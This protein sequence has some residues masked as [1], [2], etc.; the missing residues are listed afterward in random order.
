MSVVCAE[1]GHPNPDGTKFCGECGTRLPA[2]PVAPREVRKVV[3]VLF[4]D[5]TGSTALGERLDPEALR[6]LMTR[7]FATM[8]RIIEAH[9]GTVEKFIGDAVMAVFGIPQVHE[10]DALRAVRAAD[11]IRTALAELNA[12]LEAG[13]GFAIRFRTGLMTGEV[14]AADGASATT[15]VTGDTVNTAARLEQA[16]PPGEILLGEPTYRLVRDAVEVEPV[17]AFEAKGKALPVAAY[18]LLAVHAGAAG[19][20]RRLDTPLVGRERELERLAQAYQDA[21]AHERC[22]LFTLLGTAGVGKSR[23]VADFT[24]AIGDEATVL[25]GRCLSYGDGITYWPISEIVRTASGIVEGDGPDAARAKLAALVAGVRDGG[26]VADRVAA[27]VGL[28]DEPSSAEDVFWAIRR[29]LEHLARERRLVVVIEDIH[30]AEP[31]LLDLIEHIADWSRDAPILLLCPARPELLDAR[32]SWGGGKLNATTVL[33]EPLGSDATSRLIGLLPG[34]SALPAEVADR[35]TRAAEGNPLY[36]EE[37]LG[38][39]VDDGLLVATPGGGWTA[40]AALAELRVPPS[41]GALLAARLE[42]LGSVERLVAEHASVVGRVFEQDAVAALTPAAVRPEVRSALMALVRKELVRPDR[43]DV[44]AGDA[45][46]FRHVLIRDAAYEALPKAERAT[47][48]ERFAD[49]LVEV[50]G[51]RLPEFEAIVGYHLETAYRYAVELGDTGERTETLRRRAWVRLTDA[52]RRALDASDVGA[53]TALLERADGLSTVVDDDRVDLCADLMT[54][55]VLSGR[56]EEAL[57]EAVKV[58][59]LADSVGGS[60]VDRATVSVLLARQLVGN[61]VIPMGDVEALGD[62]LTAAGD[63]LGLSYLWHARS[64]DAWWRARAGPAVQMRAAAIRHA[65]AAHAPR[66][67]RISLFVFAT[68]YG[69]IPVAEA[70]PL[71]EA[72]LEAVGTD[73]LAR[74]E[75]LADL[76]G[77]RRSRA[78]SRRDVEWLRSCVRSSMTS[79]SRRWSLDRASSSP[80]SSVSRASRRGSSDP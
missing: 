34:G 25:R 6:A 76:A 8:R 42:R 80:R 37:L 72:T 35:V 19:R 27:A 33:L 21:V 43:A 49:W 15:L 40:T 16:A 53:A 65:Q 47:L 14:V 4:A 39:L 13:R 46:A 74:V 22:A 31:T 10:D 51:E 1:C 64:L 32:P 30:W 73:R 44:G 48:H 79:V 17:P 59:S 38:M 11:G 12:E 2:S 9:G 67:E 41:I 77:L 45:Y 20:A 52:G 56:K 75:A 5:V 57:A 55:L 50:A 70:I 58:G 26:L 61:M 24:R 66:L 62:R 3:T 18:R 36:L 63:E 54:A 78:T 71:V 28:I 29:L 7:Y 60:A 69:P 23:L 68:F